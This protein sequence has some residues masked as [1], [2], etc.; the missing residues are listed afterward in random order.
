MLTGTQIRKAACSRFE[1]LDKNQIIFQAFLLVG[2]SL[3]LCFIFQMNEI[4]FNRFGILLIPVCLRYAAE[5]RQQNPVKQAMISLQAMAVTN[6]TE[7]R[8]HS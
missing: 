1:H 2:L 3:N 7:F 5:K 4:R 6:F 8:G